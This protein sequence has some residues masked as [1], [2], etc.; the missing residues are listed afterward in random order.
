MSGQPLR[1]SDR[2]R[3]KSTLNLSGS[4]AVIPRQK[5]AALLAALPRPCAKM[6]SFRQKR[7]MSATMRK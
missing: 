1:L 2:K 5:Q 6:P 4:T 3:S 7:M